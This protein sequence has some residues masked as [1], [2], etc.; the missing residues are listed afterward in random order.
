MKASQAE[1]LLRIAE[2]TYA[3]GDEVIAEINR[4]D[5]IGAVHARRLMEDRDLLQRALEI[6]KQDCERFAHYMPREQ[7]REPQRELGNKNTSRP[8]LAPVKKAVAE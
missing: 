6:N 2:N 4:T 7:H 1:V 5:R 8:V 3:E